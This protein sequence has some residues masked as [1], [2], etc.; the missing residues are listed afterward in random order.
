MYLVP[1]Y[2]QVQHTC[3]SPTKDEDLSPHVHA[4][5]VQVYASTCQQVYISQSKW[6]SNWTTRPNVCSQQNGGP[7]G[8]HYI[9]ATEDSVICRSLITSLVFASSHELLNLV[10]PHLDN[11]NMVLARSYCNYQKGFKFSWIPLHLLFW[12]RKQ[13]CHVLLQKLHWLLIQCKLAILASC[14]LHS[15][16][17][18]YISVGLCRIAG[19]EAWCLQSIDIQMSHTREIISDS[20]SEVTVDRI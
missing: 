5:D 11:C 18:M 8:L 6:L 4:D 10:K 16:V 12:G 19:D 1:Q 14:C 15:L 7:T 13:Q 17:L 20:A 3:N 2:V 9:P